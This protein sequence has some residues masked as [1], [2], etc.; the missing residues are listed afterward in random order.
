M[1]TTLNLS[2]KK[3]ICGLMLIAILWS[4]LPASAQDIAEKNVPS[5][6]QKTFSLKYPDFSEAYWTLK[7][8]L[9]GV[10]FN[11]AKGYLD[12]WFSPKGKWVRTERI[13]EFDILPKAVVD[14]LHASQFG[15]WDIG[16]VYTLEIPGRAARYKLYVYSANWDEL[17]LIFEANGKLILDIP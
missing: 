4:N 5:E 11:T 14:S 17:E 10:S 2:S 1:H 16:N 3:Y 8:G 15:N 13:I 6:V 12:A 7:D 9:Y